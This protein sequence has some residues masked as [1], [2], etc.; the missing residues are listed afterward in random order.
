[1][2]MKFKPYDD[3]QGLFSP[4]EEGSRVDSLVEEAGLHHTRWIE[5]EHD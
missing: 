2:N 4:N 3:D 1:M 5:E